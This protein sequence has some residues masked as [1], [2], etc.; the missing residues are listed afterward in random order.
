MGRGYA[1]QSA[2]EHATGK[3]VALL[4]A[5]GFITNKNWAEKMLSNFTGDRIAAVF[6]LSRAINSESSIARYWDYLTTTALIPGQITHGAGTGNTLIKKSVLDE[7]GGFDKRLRNAEDSDLSEKISKKG[8]V[9]YYEPD[10][11]M[12]REQPSSIKEVLKKEIDYTF[13]HGK[14]AHYNNTFL[15]LF[16][17]RF[18]ILLA[19]P[20]F[21]L[22]CLYISV[23]MYMHT[24]DFAS[25]W[26]LFF[27]TVMAILAPFIL[28]SSLYRNEL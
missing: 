13:W 5:D 26:F 2:L 19:L 22:Y 21:V 25:F 11:L 14:R 8:Y 16:L 3:Y 15:K 1:R 12:S 10:C 18:L 6:S 27:K 7:V 9:F 17:V 28:L 23:K 24:K 4:D 20:I